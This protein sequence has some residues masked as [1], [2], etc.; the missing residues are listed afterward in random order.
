[1]WRVSA[2]R[3]RRP[4]TGAGLDGDSMRQLKLLSAV[5]DVLVLGACVTSGVIT[6][7]ALPARAGTSAPA[8]T[9]TPA[10][11]SAPAGIAALTG[12]TAPAG[13]APPAPTGW[14][15][16]FRDDFAG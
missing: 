4:G 12:N 15:T 13:T 9:S 10:G 11:T 16:V 3:H 5:I 8:G 1:M 7:A 6:L 14:T 2:V